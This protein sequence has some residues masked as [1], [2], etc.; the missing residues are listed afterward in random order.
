MFPYIE[1]FGK[2]YTL[3]MI[4]SVIGIFVAGIFMCYLTRKR[5]LNDNDSI[6]LLLFAAIGVL[7]GGH[8]LYGITNIK[9]FHTFFKIESLK[10]FINVVAT[11]FGGSVFYGGL[12]GGLIAGFIT[13][14]CKKMNVKIFSDMAAVIIPL[15]HFFAR[16]GCFLSG[17]CYG[18]ESKFGF[19]V[20]NNT[21][22]EGINGVQRFPVQL[23]EAFC[24]LI[25]FIALYFIY[26]KSLKC[27]ALEGKLLLI[28]LSCY[29]VIRFFDEFLRGDEIRGFI[30]GFSTSQFISI[31]LFCA[32]G[33]GLLMSLKKKV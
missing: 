26:K 28:Y 14:K 15:F 31:I 20:H 18:I 5:G 33:L 3:Y 2:I 1:F 24:N 30:F 10:E 8:I 21:L 17:C 6:I 16:I 29:P 23:L 22:V 12:F 4:M 13:L 11:I 25:L 32:A 19:T 9:Y 7:L 27:K